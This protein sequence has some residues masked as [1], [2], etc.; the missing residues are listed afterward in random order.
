MDKGI[1]KEVV[2]EDAHQKVVGLCNRYEGRICAEEGE[3]I[4]VVK[5]GERRGERVCKGTAEKGL[6]SAIEITTNGAGVLC[7]EKGWEKEDGAGL[8][9]S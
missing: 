2:G 1:W 6:H 9:L 5:E 8:S 7:R 4:S 3:G